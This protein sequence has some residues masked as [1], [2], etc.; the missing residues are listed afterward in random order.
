VVTGLEI[1]KKAEKADRS[2][3]RSKNVLPLLIIALC[4][5]V[6]YAML[7]LST[8]PVYLRDER[9]FGEA[10][11]GLVLTSFLLSEAIFKS[12]MGTLCDRMG[13]RLFIILGPLLSVISGVLSLL[14]PKQD[15]S[16]VESLVF[17]GLRVID[18]IGIAMLWPAAFAEI[19]RVVKDD[20]RQQAMS[21]MNFCYLLGIALAFPLGG[22]VNDLSG[23]KSAGIAL[24][25]AF[26]ALAGLLALRFVPQGASHAER[27]EQEAHSTTVAGFLQSLKSIPS[28]LILAIVT[29]TGIGL[30]TYTFKFFP[31]DEFKLSE[32]QIGALVFPGAIAMAALNLP[33]GH[34][35]SR[36][37]RARSVH[38]GLLLCAVGMWVIGSGMFAP[39]M[40][41]P[42]LLALGGVPVGLGFLLA[43]P[44]WLAS[45][46][47]LDTTR[48]AGNLGAIMT[49]Q[50]LGAIIG[51]PVGLAMYEKLAPVGE[52]IHVGTT[53][54]GP[55]FGRYSPFVA[56]AVCVTVAFLFSLRILK[57]EPR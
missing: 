21:L 50:G 4:A 24:A 30:P 55:S 13:A 36:I 17:I 34:L 43:I 39:A 6:G 31:A 46:S 28:Y 19:N 23:K 41:N 18:G 1:G 16:V 7:N 38:I 37:G 29:F 2:L 26:L 53:T 22:I 25:A 5:E 52:T 10:S 12:P 56:T 32:T 11:S 47:E 27:E 51:A 8:M 20:Q 9:N 44:S 3:W 15:G 49:A 35:A 40:R 57:P 48:R 45:V 54:L 14:V 42:W 33:M